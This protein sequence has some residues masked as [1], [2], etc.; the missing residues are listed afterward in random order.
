MDKTKNLFLALLITLGLLFAGCCAS[1]I[2]TFVVDFDTEATNVM[3]LVYLV[4]HLLV[5][6]ITF[7]LAFKAY[8]TGKSSLLEIFT[9]NEKGQLIKKTRVVA[10]VISAI[11]WCIAIYA[12]LLVCGLEIP[13]SFFAPALK[14]A[15]MNFGYSVAIVAIYFVI[16]PFTKK[17]GE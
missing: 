6:A 16:Y 13:L 17:Q 10:I 3:A 4:F 2:G 8:Y 5:I 14:H 7:Y 15:L 11:F 1:I 12:T 9:I